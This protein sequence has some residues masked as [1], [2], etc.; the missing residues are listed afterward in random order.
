MKIINVIVE[1]RSNIKSADP[2]ILSYQYDEP[3][4]DPAKALR[5]AVSDYVKA[6]T[7]ET[8]AALIRANGYF[9]WGDVATNIPSDYFIK[10]GLTPITS[11]SYEYSV[12]HDEILDD[13]EIY[14]RLA[15]LATDIDAFMFAF[16]QHNYQDN[17]KDREAHV[18]DIESAIQYGGDF[19][20]KT[21]GK[22]KYAA[23][24]EAG[25]DNA[26]EANALLERLSR[27]TPQTGGDQ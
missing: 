8:N 9:N 26:A 12:E 14:E 11:D 21:I 20:E 25:Y 27:L 17:I 5:E 15:Q 19:L 7:V 10:R 3:V 13:G 6:D 1:D 22:L 4:T 24:E 23:S 18:N 16:D 2:F